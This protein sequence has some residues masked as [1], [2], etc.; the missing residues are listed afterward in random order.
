MNF[1]WNGS[2]WVAGANTS[3][4]NLIYSSDGITWTASTNGNTVISSGV[5]TIAWN[6]AV[7]IAGGSNNPVDTGIST[8]GIYWRTNTS[9]TSLFPI[10][11]NLI[12]ASRSVLPNAGTTPFINTAAISYIPATSGNWV[13]PAPITLKAA[14]DRIAAAVSTLRTSAIP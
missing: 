11:G 12:F 6:G 9:I 14:I 5:Y 7:W 8:D 2:R 10:S 3:T 13:S 1:A 4:N